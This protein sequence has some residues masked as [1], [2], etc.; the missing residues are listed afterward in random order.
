MENQMPESDNHDFHQNPDP[1]EQLLQERESI[2]VSSL[3]QNSTSTMT[4]NV[5]KTYYLNKKKIYFLSLLLFFFIFC[6]FSNHFST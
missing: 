2:E 6:I 1:I 5:L 4:E 3:N